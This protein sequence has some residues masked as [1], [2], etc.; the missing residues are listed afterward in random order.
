MQ[1][2]NPTLESAYV[3]HYRAYRDTSLIIEL[4][5]EHFGRISAVA[6]GARTQRS[7]WRGLLLPGVPLL[8]TCVG[9]NE[10][11]TLTQ[12]EPNGSPLMLQGKALFSLF[13]VNELLMHLLH[14]FDPHP[15]LFR[16]YTQTLTQLIAAI[17]IEIPLRQFEWKLLQELGYELALD[18]DIS[19]NQPIRADARY[20]IDL[21]RGASELT[22]NI[23]RDS[24]IY[25]GKTLQA[26]ANHM[27]LDDPEIL[28]E[29]KRLTRQ[30]L[31]PLLGNRE[32]VSR[33]LFG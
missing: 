16:Q 8:V 26:L 23:L 11:L 27:L 14:R 30:L 1:I 22:D 25:Q 19:T 7:P 31:Q 2:D 24:P 15:Q 17:Q 20:Q 29:A 33:T 10:L 32:I 12:A 21:E 4:F 5:T 3:L 9:R 13:Y 18:K 28:R 6:K